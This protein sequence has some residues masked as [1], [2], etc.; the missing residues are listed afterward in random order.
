MASGLALKLYT[1]KEEI[2]NAKAGVSTIVAWPEA[3]KP[4]GA[5]Y[6]VSAS[7][8][9]CDVLSGEVRINTSKQDDEMKKAAALMGE[10]MGKELEKVFKSFSE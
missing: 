4:L 8:E 1:T 5:Y 6:E 10:A 2:D 9:I 7:L 3:N